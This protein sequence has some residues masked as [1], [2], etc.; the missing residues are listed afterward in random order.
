ME[1]IVT[2]EFRF[3]KTPDGQV[4]TSSAFQYGFWLRYL[5]AFDHLIVVARVQAVEQADAG[6]KLSSGDRVSFCCLPYYVGLAGL[7][8]NLWATAKILRNTLTPGRAIIYRVPSQTAMLSSLV[9]GIRRHHYGLEVVG[10]PAD[11][12]DSGIVNGFTDK[13][14]GW[15]SRTALQ[16]MVKKAHSVSYVTQGY[17]QQRYPASSAAYTT[18]CSSIELQ[19]SWISTEPKQFNSPAKQWLFVGSFGQLYKGPDLLINALAEL[20]KVIEDKSQKYQLT[21][22]GGGVYK[23]DMQALAQSLGCSDEVDFV[24]EVNAAQV[25]DYLNRAEVFVMP[26]RTEGLPRALIEAMAT[27]LPAIGSRVGGIPELLND[28]HLF[29]SE[30]TAELAAKLHQL[31][32]SVDALNQ[33]SARNIRVASTYEASI[34]NGRRQAFYQHVKQQSLEQKEK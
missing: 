33:A 17:L 32:S 1:L 3:F 29:E 31:C 30:N 23:D 13:M 11:V 24:G 4:W 10:D 14:L 20:N 28:A 9:Q 22:L 5:D 7:L 15:I 6:W 16:R 2:C 12:F 34:L 8:K 25:K 19:A 21:L 27:G 26:S 18:A